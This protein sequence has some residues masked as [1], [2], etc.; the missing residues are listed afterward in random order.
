M[1]SYFSVAVLAIFLPATLLVYRL[2]TRRARWIVLLV[3]SYVFFWSISGD[4]IVFLLGS[5]VSI[6][7]LGLRLG[8][9]QR[10]RRA[11]MKRAGADRRA[12]KRAYRRR[13]RFWLALGVAAN[14]GALI[15]VKYLGFFGSL[16]A[17]LG[18]RVPWVVPAVGIPIGISFYTLQAASYLIDVYRCTIP[19]DRNLARLALFMAF[20]PEMTEG[21]IC[22]YADTAEQLWAGS[23]VT[24]QNLLQGSM[25]ILYGLAKRMVVANRLNAFVKPVFEGY[26]SFDGGMIALAAVLYTFQLYCDF[27][28]TM[29]FVVGTGQM[30]GVRM[31]ENFRQPFLSKTASEFW[32]RW[33][34]TLGT[35][36][37]DYVFYPISLSGPVKRFGRFARRRLGN[38]Y[39]SIASSAIALFFVWLGNGLWHGAGTQYVLFGMYYF[40]LILAGGAI[41]PTVAAL[42]AK[43][44][45]D[46][47]AAWYR[48]LRI[49]RTIA[50]ICTGEMLFRA[51]SAQAALSMVGA[52]LTR[53]SLA[54]LVDGTALAVGMDAADF[55]VV[56]C[57]LI[58]IVAV[59]LAREHG[60]SPSETICRGRVPLRWAVL[61]ALAM[62]TVVFG[63]YGAGYMPVD[64]MYAQF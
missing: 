26:A 18:I 15:A 33:H 41:E 30:F 29:D 6:W 7:A 31:P 3:A 1:T 57:A 13:M 59:S 8:A 25:R 50:V 46:R 45:I 24:A 10:R 20:F 58:V 49:A 63:A 28:G 38:V 11:A 12:I 40:V 19:A 51:S 37:R 16:V 47:D 61:C 35:W 36:L 34:I 39:G 32:Q 17:G 54:S 62:A 27:S 44:G 43:A 23:D 4:L 60:A 52:V 2:T 42:C 21:P 9:L 55:V 5:T 14:F 56:G 64:P 53:F 48:R 22:R